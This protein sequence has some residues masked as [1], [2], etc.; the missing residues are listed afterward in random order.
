[1]LSV[2]FGLLSMP[3]AAILKCIPVERDTTKQHHDGYEA[4]PPGPES[5]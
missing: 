1:L 4:L 5:V 2:L 3:L